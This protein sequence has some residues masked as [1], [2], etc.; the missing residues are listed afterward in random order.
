VTVVLI[1]SSPFDAPAIFGLQAAG[2]LS[3]RY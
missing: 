1:T 3:V 2:S